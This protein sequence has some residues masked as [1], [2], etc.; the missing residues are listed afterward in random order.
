MVTLT[1]PALLALLSALGAAA[2]KDQC[3][4]FTAS[5]PNVVIKPTYYPAGALVNLTSPSSSVTTT[6]MPAFCRLALTITTN[7]TSGNQA[8]TEVWMPDD[9][10]NRL[11]GFGNGGLSG[12]VVYSSLS[13]DGIQQGYSS[14]STNTGHQSNP[15]NGTWALNNPNAQLDFGFRAFQLSYQAAKSLTEQ[16]YKKSIYKKYYLGCSTA[17]R[18]GLVE[19]QRYPED[20]DGI[21]IG[22]PANPVARLS[23]WNIYQG[24][25][26]LPVNG[27]RWIPA[28]LWSVIHDEVMKQCDGID[29]LVDG[30][31][32]DP[33]QCNF[34]PEAIAC[35]PSSNTSTCLTL[36]QIAA[37][38]ALYTDWH[39]SNGTFLFSRF[40]PG[41]ELAY[42][43]SYVSGPN[44]ALGP[45]YWKNIIFSN[46]NWDYNTL[47]VEDVFRAIELNPGQIDNHSFNYTSYFARGGKLLHYAGL[48]DQIISSGNSYDLYN[49]VSAFT[50]ANTNL[51]PYDYYRFFPI[52]GMYHCNGGLGAN[53]FGGGG[54]RSGGTPPLAVDS[55]HDV[56]AA[57]VNWVENGQAPTELIAAKYTNNNVTQGVQFTRKLCPYPQKGEYQGGDP[58]SSDSFKCM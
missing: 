17:G 1:K 4:S 3:E 23:A 22:S 6:K 48:A 33:R 36:G 10:N 15:V 7:A 25:Q 39:A 14:F 35:G 41:G 58:N 26:V 28:P 19:A 57:M 13:Y 16:Y 44:I 34:R 50:K 40:E 38:K 32:N 9:W 56:L 52:P 53:A 30:V 55:K 49:S 18:M 54:Q 37:V 5:I 27:T 2:W 46:P 12:G 42:A 21:V 31:I 43:T 29:G 47:T 8:L 51:D 20:F 11:L 45:E 24:R